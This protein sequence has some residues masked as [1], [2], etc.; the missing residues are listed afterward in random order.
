[1]EL[2][3]CQWSVVQHGLYPGQLEAWVLGNWNENLCISGGMSYFAMVKYPQA[4][5]WCLLGVRD[6]ALSHDA[7]RP[8]HLH[9]LEAL[10]LWNVVWYYYSSL[11]SKR[12]H[13]Q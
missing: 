13:L 9:D 8:P 1:M 10:V 4:N 11:S 6:T 3:L 12:H 2:F 7:I 5:A